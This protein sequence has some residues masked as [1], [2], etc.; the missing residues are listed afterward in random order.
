MK[1][2]FLNEFY[3]SLEETIDNESFIKSLKNL[4]DEENLSQETLDELI[5]EV[6][7]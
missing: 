2:Q 1:S 5:Q 7:K 4:I 3:Q 6:V